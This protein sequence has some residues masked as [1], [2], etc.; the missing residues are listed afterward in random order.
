MG[1]GIACHDLRFGYHRAG[2]QL[3]NRISRCFH[4]LLLLLSC[5][6]SFGFAFLAPLVRHYQA[7]LVRFP[8]LP[9][10]V[11]KTGHKRTFLEGWTAKIQLFFHSSKF[12]N[13]V[14]WVFGIFMQNALLFGPFS[15][16][17][18]FL[19]SLVSRCHY[20]TSF[21]RHFAHSSTSHPLILS[22]PV[23]LFFFSY[24]SSA[25]RLLIVCSSA[26]LW[27]T[28]SVLALYPDGKK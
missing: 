26:A 23:F 19:P 10:F 5:S 4:F 7:V 25:H 22:P 17:I 3:L 2:I 20:L 1:I 18:P 6:F 12:F 13:T 21:T 8:L 11:L 24:L 16:K 28:E 15:R 9:S 27:V 14:F